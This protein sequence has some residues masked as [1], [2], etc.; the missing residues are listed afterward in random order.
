MVTTGQSV[1]SLVLLVL[2]MVVLVMVVLVLVLVLVL[3]TI[4]LV[5]RDAPAAKM[6][7]S[8]P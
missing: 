7:T 3:S 1:R 6:S 8:R 2:V 5:Q 4:L